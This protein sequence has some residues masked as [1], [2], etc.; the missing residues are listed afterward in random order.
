VQIRDPNQLQLRGN[1]NKRCTNN[2]NNNNKTLV[3]QGAQIS[4]E[5]VI[6]WQETH[7]NSSSSYLSNNQPKCSPFWISTDP[8][9]NK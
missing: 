3:F 9:S 8:S 2:N 6:P 4:V 1:N 7:C 5:V